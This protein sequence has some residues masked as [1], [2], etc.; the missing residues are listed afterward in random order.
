[1]TK[2][3]VNCLYI[4]GLH[5]KIN[6]AKIE[7]LEKYFDK[8]TALNIDYLNQPDTFYILKELCEK[9]SVDFIVGSSFGGYFG[10]YLSR[11][12]QLPSVLFNPSLYF[13]EQD[14]I[15]IKEK[16]IQSSPFSYFV[17]GEKDETVPLKTTQEFISKNEIGDNIHTVSCNW[18][19]HVIDLKTF[20]AMMQSG[21][22]LSKM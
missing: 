10:F 17:M 3:Y 11:A 9:E 15:F 2:H 13:G 21:I 12:L 7:I 18:L 16:P 1:M 5:S 4:H 6:D 14:S 8:T 19:P 20:D 22:E